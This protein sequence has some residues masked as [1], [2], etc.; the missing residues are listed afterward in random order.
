MRAFFSVAVAV[1]SVNSVSIP[2]SA[3]L[4]LLL[5]V[6]FFS[7]PNDWFLLQF[8]YFFRCRKVYSGLNLLVRLI[9]ELAWL[10]SCFELE[11]CRKVVGRREVELVGNVLN[12]QVGG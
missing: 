7:L 9:A 3:G 1:L 2:S 10:Q 11:L 12:A 4:F 6:Y 5:V 8:V